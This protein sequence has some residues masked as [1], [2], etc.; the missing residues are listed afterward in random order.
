MVEPSR[1]AVIAESIPPLLDAGYEDRILLSHDVCWKTSLKAYG[2]L[3]YSFI[4]EQFLPRLRD[5]GVTESQTDK[6]MVEN[7]KRVLTFVAPRD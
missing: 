7:A 1:T 2:G 3:G 4:L 6:A 5:L